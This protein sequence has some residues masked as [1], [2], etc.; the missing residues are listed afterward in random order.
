VA[1]VKRA[2]PRGSNTRP[3]RPAVLFRGRHFAAFALAGLPADCPSG[4]VQAFGA[5]PWG[6]RADGL[7]HIGQDVSGDLLLYRAGSR[8][9]NGEAGESGAR[10]QAQRR[11]RAEQSA[12]ANRLQKTRHMQ[13]D[14]HHVVFADGKRGTPFLAGQPVEPGTGRL[15]S[16]RSFQWRPT[17][18]QNGWLPRLKRS[19]EDRRALLA[20]PLPGEV[21]EP[22]ASRPSQRPPPAPTRYPENPAPRFR[23]HH[24]AAR[25]T[26]AKERG[27][28]GVDASADGLHHRDRLHAA[29]VH[30]IRCKTIC[31]FA[32]RLPGQS[33][34]AGRSRRRKTRAPEHD[35]GDAGPRGRP[36]NFIKSHFK[37]LTWPQHAPVRI[38]ELRA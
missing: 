8:G 19:V 11:W 14:R 38:I 21:R 29:A 10:L 1:T 22:L 13:R 33:F 31:R 2:A 26:F 9:A 6:S 20:F 7:Y 17:S 32:N 12:I 24:E 37:S 5:A 4:P 30:R 15:Q 18:A 25:N 16:E 3:A 34:L 27:R 23:S 28:T 35:S 36:R